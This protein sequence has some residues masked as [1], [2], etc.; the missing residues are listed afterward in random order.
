MNEINTKNC[1]AC[2]KKIDKR[3]KKCPYC[4]HWQGMSPLVFNLLPTFILLLFMAFLI[5]FMV[6]LKK[7]I[8]EGENFA[9]YKDQ[10][11]VTDTKIKFGEKESRGPTVVIL[12]TLTNTSNISWKNIHFEVK[13]FNAKGEHVDTDNEREYFLLV[14]AKDSVSFKV[15]LS[16]E[17][18]EKEYNACSV[19]VVSAKDVRAIW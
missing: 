19:R 7:E 9:P 1:K 8:T 11:S 16:R 13:F 3:T 17:F 18:P 10:L 15:S 2:F 6:L 12:G 14:P 4:H 5:M